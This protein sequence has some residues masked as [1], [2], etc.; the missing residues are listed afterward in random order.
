MQ[1]LRRIHQLAMASA[2]YPGATHSRFEH[3][4]GVYHIASAICDRLGITGDDRRLVQRAALLHDVGHGPFSHV[5]EIPLARYSDNDCLADKDLGAEEVHEAVTADI[6]ERHP[7]LNHVL[8]P[9]ER[10][11][12]AGLI[13]GTYPDPIAKAI[14][15]GPLDA[16]KQDYLLRDSQMCGVRYGIFDL[17]RLVQSLT[18][19]PD[20]DGEKALAIHRDGVHV[21]E[22]FLMAKY[23]ITNQVYSHRVRLI[24][25]QML[26]R[27][28]I[29]GVEHDCI[30]E[31]RQL[32]A[33]DGTDT[34]VER[35]SQWDDYRFLARFSDDSFSSSYCAKM[36][37]ALKCRRHHKQVFEANLM[38][39]G[40]SARNLIEP[41]DDLR[42]RI[43]GLAA[44]AISSELEVEV[45]PLE[46]I[47]YTYGQKAIWP[48]SGDQM[49]GMLVD[50]DGGPRPFEQRSTF[51][52]SIEAMRS[53]RFIGIIA[54]V[55]FENDVERDRLRRALLDPLHAAIAR[56]VE[57]PHQKECSE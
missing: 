20:G 54:P 24:T 56:A 33:Y 32:Y 46:V 57:A 17:D 8:S 4:L 35:Y 25:D 47:C 11:A 7:A 23:Y 48:G 51:C 39:F 36:L 5:S 38:H 14:I 26:V 3:S 50:E 42:S 6:I 12:A 16:D 52:Q 13:R 1:R 45:D 19:V 15:S 10:E 28:V 49:G 41:S 44:E 31:L 18:T 53:E 43:E 27:A 29:L 9:R 34:F 30:E 22:Q 55:V 2:L 37:N 21:V 40:D